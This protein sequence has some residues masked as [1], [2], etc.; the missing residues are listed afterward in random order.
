MQD[1]LDVTSNE[2]A[3][4]NSAVMNPHALAELVAGRRIPWKRLPDAPQVL[5]DILQTSCGEQ[6][7]SGKGAEPSIPATLKN[8]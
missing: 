8:V 3:T 2:D 1:R 4:R 6:G 7:A 5:S